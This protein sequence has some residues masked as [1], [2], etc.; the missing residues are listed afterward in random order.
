V[1]LI[2]PKTAWIIMCHHEPVQMINPFPGHCCVLHEFRS[3]QRQQI[4]GFVD[5]FLVDISHMRGVR[6]QEQS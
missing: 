5:M 3:H 6:F 2:E 1:A 4:I